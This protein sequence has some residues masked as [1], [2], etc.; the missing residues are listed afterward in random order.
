MSFNFALDAVPYLIDSKREEKNGDELHAA[1]KLY[2]V[3]LS[4]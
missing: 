4:P 2:H 1:M 3:P